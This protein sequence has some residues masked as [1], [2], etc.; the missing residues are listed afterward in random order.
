MI[1]SVNS[2]YFLKERK[3]VDLR[4][5]EELCFLR[6]TYVLKCYLDEFRLQRVNFSDGSDLITGWS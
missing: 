2:D 5:G 6:G 4:N 1:L 3:P